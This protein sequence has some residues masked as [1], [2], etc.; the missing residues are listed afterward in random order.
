MEDRTKDTRE[1]IV[2]AAMALLKEKG[3]RGVSTKAIASLAGVNE[4]TLFR[5]FGN[6][7]NM[8]TAVMEELSYLP[9]FENMLQEDV[10]WDL[11]ADL[12]MFGL[13]YIQYFRKNGDIISIAYKE[14]GHFPE[15]DRQMALIPVKLR[16]LLIDYFETMKQKGLIR[17]CRSEAYATML[18]SMNFGFLFHQLMHGDV[19]GISEEAFL[20]DSIAIVMDGLAPA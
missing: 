9:S 11:Q 7:R 18:V 4:V 13:K 5:H 12:R 19:S 16:S 20:E 2:E 3:Y 8:F 14:I 1:R 15:L 10:V 17:D 6:K